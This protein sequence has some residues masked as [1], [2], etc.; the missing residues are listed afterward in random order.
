[1]PLWGVFRASYGGLLLRPQV[2]E[3]AV[4]LF[5]IWPGNRQELQG[6]D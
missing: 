2:G 3:D 4:V 6:V 1:M 5:L